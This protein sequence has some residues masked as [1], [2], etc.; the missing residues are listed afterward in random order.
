MS[1]QLN[2]ELYNKSVDSLCSDRNN[3]VDSE[4]KD[5]PEYKLSAYTNAFDMKYRIP[6]VDN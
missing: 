4:I 5:I 1:I 6:Q 2:E 3:K